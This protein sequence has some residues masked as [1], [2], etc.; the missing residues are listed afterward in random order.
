[1]GVVVR[2]LEVAELGELT[3]AQVEVARM[4]DVVDEVGYPWGVPQGVRRGV[5][6][7]E[8]ESEVEVCAL[9]GVEAGESACDGE[10]GK[11]ISGAMEHSAAGEH[12]G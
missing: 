4:E 3:G 7:C 1:M 5:R 8:V 12:C 6:V 11:W 9:V 2:V 10:L